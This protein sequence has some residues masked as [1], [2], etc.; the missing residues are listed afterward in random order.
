MFS[1]GSDGPES[2]SLKAPKLL[3]CNTLAR[4]TGNG[5]LSA[6]SQG[7]WLLVQFGIRG[8]SH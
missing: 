3:T 5:A 4:S 7:L 8:R 6:L 2:G 1:E